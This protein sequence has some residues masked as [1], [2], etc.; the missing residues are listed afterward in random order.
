MAKN[1]N[2]TAFMLALLVACTSLNTQKASAQESSIEVNLEILNE[3]EETTEDSVVKPANSL[4]LFENDL[5]KITKD[6]A[7]KVDAAIEN[8]NRILKPVV[9]KKD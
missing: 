1:L 9:P 7:A 5:D 6:A 4:T 3:A 2:R 8:S